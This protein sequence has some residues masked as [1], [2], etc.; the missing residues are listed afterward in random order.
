[1]RD[2]A[3]CLVEVGGVVS[4]SSRFRKYNCNG[5]IDGVIAGGSCRGCMY[6]L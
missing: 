1:M 4:I 5:V 2:E 6:L 3:M